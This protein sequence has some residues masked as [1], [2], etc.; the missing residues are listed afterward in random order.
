MVFTDRV[1]LLK[2]AVLLALWAAV[3]GAFVSVLY[4]G[5]A[6]WIRPGCVT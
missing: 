2:L 4:R 5:K 6:T 3:A 1:E